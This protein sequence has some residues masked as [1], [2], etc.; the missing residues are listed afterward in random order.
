MKLSIRTAAILASVALL[1]PSR[2]ADPDDIVLATIDG[3]DAV[4][5]EDVLY[6]LGKSGPKA[7][8]RV[9]SADVGEMVETVVDA[10]I[11]IREAE[12][13]GYEEE[14]WFKEASERFRSSTL[15]D[16]MGKK[17]V[18][19]VAITE[20]DIRAFYKHGAKWRKT[21]RII[22]KN[23]ALA[24]T[25][26]RELQRGRPWE[27]VADEYAIIRTEE[28]E[29]GWSFPVP[30]VYDGLPAS[31]AIY[32][33]AVGEHTPPVPENDGI[34]WAIYRVDKVVHGTIDTYEEARPFTKG[35]LE[36]AIFAERYDLFAKEMRQKFS[37]ERNEEMWRDLLTLPFAEFRRKW[38]MRDAAASDAG[39]VNVTGEEFVSAMLD[40]FMGT[41]NTPDEMRAED[42]A[43]FAYVIDSLLKNSED[44]ALL[45]AAA[46]KNGLDEEPKFVSANKNFRAGQLTER[47]IHERFISTLPQPTEEEARKYYDERKGEFQI[48]EKV[49]IYTVAMP[50]RQK[51]EEFYA[52]I[53][54][55]ADLV[56][57][58]EAYN[59]AEALRLIDLYEAPP[60]LP[61]E[62]EEWLGVVHIYRDPSPAEPD[63]GLAAQLR[64]RAFPFTELKELSDLF[65]L[66][67][68]RW[69]FYA[70]I[71]YQPFRQKPFE[72]VEYT[73]RRRVWEE[74]LQSEEVNKLSR[75]CVASVRAE[76]DVE[77]KPASYAA[78][79][80]RLNAAK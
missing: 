1:P 31:N 46:L 15:R 14:E 69:A 24:E 75:E 5:F 43:D 9:T 17:L 23:R 79:A 80:A 59:R 34:R 50:E 2:G 52:K 10:R 54:A 77:L 51:L 29:K 22:T 4:T 45:E 19:D 28:E 78:A 48:L 63:Q 42:P 68:G 41:G 6:Y 27:E 74:F 62:K 60:E 26:H 56:E 38:G 12:A 57:T 53:A 35:G 36:N 70:P 55:G 16:I 61:P 67:D 18:E 20:E 7:E 64:P 73:C 25:A 32:A 37:I 72:E 47:L 65:E 76:Y 30:I 39:G 58:G 3:E 21:S 40:Y 33:T 11:L 66:E 44:Y 8:A 13:R 49:E 71:F